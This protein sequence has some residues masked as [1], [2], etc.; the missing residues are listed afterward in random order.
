[1][2]I[3]DTIRRELSARFT[4]VDFTPYFVFIESRYQ[5]GKE[6]SERHHILPKSV[7]PDRANNPDNLIYLSVGDHLRAHYWIALCATECALFQRIFFA[8]SGLKKY[9]SSITMGELSYCA[10]VYE[11]G[12]KAR[13]EASIKGRYRAIDLT[14]KIIGRLSI[15]RPARTKGGRS[16]WE[17]LCDCGNTVVVDS[18]QLLAQ[19]TK[20]CGCLRSRP[21]FCDLTQQVFGRLTALKPIGVSSHKMKWDCICACGKTI[22]ATSSDLI[23][24]HTRSCGC[25][26]KD[27]MRVRGPEILR[28]Y[29]N[30]EWPNVQ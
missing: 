15:I 8:M 18:A 10:E 25:F 23:S 17:C 30:K 11:R 4:G 5:R 13:R 22:S 1:V 2:V 7:F 12:K 28:Q 9:A 29:V 26:R 19:R 27:L 20:S 6:G 14:G 21:R 3:S 24:G 16:A